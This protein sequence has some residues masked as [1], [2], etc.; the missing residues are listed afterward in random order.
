LHLLL[1]LL[2]KHRRPELCQCALH[3][4][5]AKPARN[6]GVLQDALF[7]LPRQSLKHRALLKLADCLILRVKARRSRAPFA[8]SIL[9]I[10]ELRVFL[11][12]PECPSRYSTLRFGCY[13]RILHKVGRWAETTTTRARQCH[14][15]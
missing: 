3:V 4:T 1:D 5:A 15:A 2:V 8:L 11:W 6:T 10:M 13:I 7:T 14:K 12:R 9:A